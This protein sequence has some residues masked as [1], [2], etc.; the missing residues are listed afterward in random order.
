MQSVSIQL[1]GN[2]F[3]V[4][5]WQAPASPPAGGWPSVFAVYASGAADVP[6]LLGT[7]S[8]E[9]RALT[10]RARYPLSPGVRYRAVFHQPGQRA[11]VEQTF[12]GP[13]QD[14]TPVARVD[15]VYPSADVLPSNVLRLYVYFS[16]PMSRGEAASRIHMLDA[17]GKELRGAV[18]AGRGALG[19]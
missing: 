12:D 17:G 11:V 10:F 2:V 1:D 7:Y 4:T 6:P 14:T 8:V 3:T 19:S 15:R 18:S 16:A 5:G 13:Q 9:N